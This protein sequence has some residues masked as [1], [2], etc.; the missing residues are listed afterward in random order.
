[1]IEKKIAKIGG[2]INEIGN[3]YIVV[4]FKS[5]K[6]MLHET[7]KMTSHWKDQSQK[8]KAKVNNMRNFKRD[9]ITDALG[10]KIPQGFR[11]FDK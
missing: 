1:M 4:T 6:S 9:T 5:T 7:I 8:E 11:N 10:M 3:K 2:K